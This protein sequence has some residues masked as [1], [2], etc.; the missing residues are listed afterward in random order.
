MSSANVVVDSEPLT[1]GE[2]VTLNTAVVPVRRLLGLNPGPMTGPGTNS[3]L[4]G[5][6]TLTLIDPGPIDAAQQQNF[7]RAIGS[8]QLANIFVTHTHGDH[9]P[10]AKQ[11]AE[12]TGA[13][14]VGINAPQALGQDHS[15]VSDIDCEDGAVI[16]CEDGAA[17][18]SL[19][20]IHTP[21]HVSNHL[22]FLLREEGLLFTGDHVLQG[23]TPVILPPDG[24]MSDYLASLNKLLELPLIKLAPA[25]G[26]VMDAPFT[27]IEKLIAHRLKR[28]AKILSSLRE[29]G[30]C[31]E[32]KLV[33][34]A[35]DDVAEQLLPWAKKTMSAHLI[36]LA[37]EGAA[38]LESAQWRAP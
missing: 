24:D 28:E 27:E 18:Y 5:E 38:E 4:V 8:A 7:L 29:L 14:L 36:K 10:A 3:Y 26:A 17:S 11:L 6:Q 21:G 33:R 25:H 1:P 12:L 19:Q 16:S 31:D 37:K 20:M 13:R 30:P 35:Y 9:S 22:C 32:D 15:F 34:K 23:T 2:A